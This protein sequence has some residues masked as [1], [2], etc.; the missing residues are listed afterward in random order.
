MTGSPTIGV[1]ALQGD[2]REH[3]RVLEAAG[4]VEV[5]KGFVGRRPRTSCHVTAAGRKAFRAYLDELEAV[6]EA[7]TAVARRRSS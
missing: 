6:L 7:A 1:L 4:Y 3:L 5:E 2:V